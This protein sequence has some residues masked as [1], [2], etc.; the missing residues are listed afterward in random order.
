MPLRD[1]WRV[2]RRHE[3][4]AGDAESAHA[5]ATPWMAAGYGKRNAS[6]TPEG[7]G[8]VLD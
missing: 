4:N 5:N 3:G 1:G 8:R 6:V 2:S 7:D